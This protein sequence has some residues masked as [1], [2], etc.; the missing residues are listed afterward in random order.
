MTHPRFAGVAL[1][2]ETI[3]LTREHFADISRR[4]IADAT[5]GRQHVNDLDSYVAWQESAIRDV[6][7]CERF[8]LTF[9]Q[10]AHWIQTGECVALLG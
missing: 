7:T 3:A 2:P 4:C 1:T 6:M 9:L 10:R 8:S 5:E